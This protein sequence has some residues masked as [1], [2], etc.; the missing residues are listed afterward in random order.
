LGLAGCRDGNHRRH[1]DTVSLQSPLRRKSVGRIVIRRL[2]R[3]DGGLCLQ[4][5]SRPTR[6][7]TRQRGWS[8]RVRAMPRSC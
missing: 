6:C 5:Q 2:G 1:R 3:Q 4:L 7:R 8:A